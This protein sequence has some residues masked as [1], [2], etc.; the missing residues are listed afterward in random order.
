MQKADERNSYRHG[1][2]GAHIKTS[3]LVFIFTPHDVEHRNTPSQALTPVSHLETSL[4]VGTTDKTA[5]S[6][7]HRG[8]GETNRETETSTPRTNLLWLFPR[9]MHAHTITLKSP[10][11]HP[12]THSRWYA[13]SDPQT[14]CTAL[15]LTGKRPNDL[16]F[17]SSRRWTTLSVPREH[18]RINELNAKHKM[19]NAAP[20]TSGVTGGRALTADE[21]YQ[22]SIWTERVRVNSK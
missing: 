22:L 2:L 8:K 19:R 21:N 3:L 4:V 18:Q 15:S 14:Q 17:F 16:G 11:T 5:V 1:H 13:H 12:N 7:C 9:P 6:A 10:I 20:Q